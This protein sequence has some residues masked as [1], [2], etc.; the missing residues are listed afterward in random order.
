MLASS[1]RSSPAASS[2]AKSRIGMPS[3][4]LVVSTVSAVWSQLI[5]GMTK[6]LS[7]LMLPAN[8]EIDGRFEPQIE[9]EPGRTVEGPHHV[10]G[11]QPAQV[12]G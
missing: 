3:T 8:S 10:G 5:V 2:A 9:L 4:Q 6:P 12:L 7:F 11:P 1:L